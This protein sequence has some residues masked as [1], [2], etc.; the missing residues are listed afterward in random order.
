MHAQAA[1]AGRAPGRDAVPIRR[2][3][4]RVAVVDPEF[5][6]ESLDR[7][8]ANPD[9][10]FDGT[11]S[12][13]LKTDAT[14]SVCAVRVGGEHLVIKRYNIRGALHRLSRAVRGSRAAR[15]WRVGRAM[16]AC[17]I[18]VARPV[19]FMEERL[20]PFRGRAWLVTQYCQGTGLDRFMA[21]H[22][23]DGTGEQVLSAVV[24]LFR[25]FAQHRFSH[26]D[27]KATNVLVDAGAARLID[28]DAA[29]AH[30]SRITARVAL[31]RDIER[32]L[33]NWSRQPALEARFRAALEPLGRGRS[34]R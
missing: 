26:G 15:C 13:V 3:G 11:Y 25:Q 29:R 6:G 28:L 7:L 20:G 22:A 17:G 32:F 2:R 5:A 34:R 30:R 1:G 19:A 14:T 12:L 21:A 23:G 9:R 16:R 27:M 10:Y 31:G 4:R 18:P 33:R 24:A 8:F